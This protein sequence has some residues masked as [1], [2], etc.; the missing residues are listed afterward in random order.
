MPW[1]R[2]DENAMEHPKI[3]TLPDGAFRLWVQGLAHCQK[4]L[5]DGAITGLAMRALRAYSPK[6]MTD[7]ISAG[8]WQPDDDGVTVHDYLQWNDSRDHVENAR[9]TAKERMAK[10]RGCS[11][12]HTPNKQGTSGEVRDTTSPTPLHPLHP[13]RSEKQNEGAVVAD[14]RSKRPIFKG[15]RFVVF[16]WMLDDLSR[17][18]GVHANDFDLH[19]W[20]FD[21]D[22]KAVEAG[23][24]VPQRDG[25]KWLQEQTQAEAIRRGLPIAAQASH[26]PK[27]AGNLAAA[28]RFVARGQK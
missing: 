3:V 2:L 17:M 24:V 28:A 19:A 5:T 25:G 12:E 16:E 21:L 18:L 13:T 7:L 22:A 6:R 9:R 23:I 4:F 14:H 8:L 26:N 10:L 1:V 27:T 20:F 15:Q 11:R